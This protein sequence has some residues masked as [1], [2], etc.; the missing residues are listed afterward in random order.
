MADDANIGLRSDSA[1]EQ[2]DNHWQ[3]I[4]ALAAVVVVSAAKQAGGG[5]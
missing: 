3:P 4:G 2:K 5:K 1:S